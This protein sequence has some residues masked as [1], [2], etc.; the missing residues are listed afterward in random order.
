MRFKTLRKR[1]KMVSCQLVRLR[2]FDTAQAMKTA[3]ACGRMTAEVSP[4]QHTN[5]AV[6]IFFN[7]RGSAREVR[8]E[9]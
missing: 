2:M 8:P 3:D 4:V 7:E 1:F 6:P 5:A 9:Q